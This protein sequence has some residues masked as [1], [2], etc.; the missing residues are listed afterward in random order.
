WSAHSGGR[1]T[2]VLGTNVS[3]SSGGGTQRPNRVANGSL[4]ADQRS[5]TRWFDTSAFTTPALYTFGNS[6]TG[7]LTAAGYFDVDLG[8]VRA[9]RV[10]EG[11]GLNLGGEAFNAFNRANFN[12][13]NATIGTAQA[14][15]I[16]STQPARVIQ[17]A[18]KLMF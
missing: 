2:P 11:M 18:V 7:I 10:T 3:N 12:A 4:P 14:G 9:S 16:N 15:V 6:G 5:I 8:V 13:P 17:V 1:F